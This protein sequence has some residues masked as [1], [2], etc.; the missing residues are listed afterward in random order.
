MER[1]MNTFADLLKN[2]YQ[3]KRVLI[4][5]HTGFK[6]SW[7]AVWLSELGADVW[8]YA[9]DP[10]TPRD[11][12][13]L[14]N[15]ASQIS[16]LRGDV[17]DLGSFAAA[18]SQAKP[19]FVFHLAAQPLVVEGYRTPRDT[20]DVN[21][22][23]TVNML[24]LCRRSDSARTI[25]VVT[26]D[27]CYESREWVWGYRECD[28]LGG[29][30]PYSSSKACTELVVAAYRNSFFNPEHYE[31]HG[32]ALATVRAGNVIGGGDWCADRIVPDCIRALEA[33]KAISV[34][35]PNSI[36]PWQLVLEPLG[37][38]L[39]LGARMATAPR[40]FAGAWNFGPEKSST[41]D[42]GRLVDM[43][44]RNWGSGHWE[45]T[46]TEEQVHETSLLSLDI[47]KATYQLGWRPALGIEDAVS[48]TVTWYKT[49]QARG[50]IPGLCQ[51]QVKRYMEEMG[52][53][54]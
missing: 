30:D 38:Y 15:I 5:G 32:K 28:G 22:M 4:T 18:L 27:K 51:Q 33:G 13:V 12:F 44:I 31:S 9:L 26:S 40:K 24:D 36:R 37:G 49:W 35:S 54:D 42:V 7:L 23:G 20:F 14:S 45:F 50:D 47:S 16:D 6:G 52:T 25:I 29:Y 1:Q 53:N 11:N 17:R 2:T 34:R 10:R 19:E 3:G 41:I 21:I 39:L 43:V 46:G 48:Q 8:G